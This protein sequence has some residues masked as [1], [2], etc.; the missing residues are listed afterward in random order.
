ME[1]ALTPK[2]RTWKIQ[3][4]GIWCDLVEP[5]STPVKVATATDILEMEDEAQQA[6]FREVRAQLAQD[7]TTMCKFNSDTKDANRRS[8]VVKVTHEKSQLE[9]GKQFLA[10]NT[11]SMRCPL[12][13][14]SFLWVRPGL[15]S[16][17]L[18]L[19]NYP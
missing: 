17:A 10:K 3:H 5:P 2:L 18:S 13:F 6:R 8:H 16:L 9:L 19:E 7:C 14:V 4:L 11:F 15:V 1:A 12:C